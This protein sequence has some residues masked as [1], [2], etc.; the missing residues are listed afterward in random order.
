MI[1][2]EMAWWWSLLSLAMVVWVPKKL[3]EIALDGAVLNRCLIG[4][5][6]HAEKDIVNFVSGYLLEFR[7]KLVEL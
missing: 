1:V 5:V 7:W 6:L 4:P 3:I 2:G